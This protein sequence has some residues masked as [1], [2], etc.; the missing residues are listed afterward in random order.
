MLLFMLYS[1]IFK[2][3]VLIILSPMLA[4]LSEKTS[5]LLTGAVYPFSFKNF[6]QD[7]WR[8]IRIALRNTFIE[9]GWI[10]LFW[11]IG[12]VPIIGFISPVYLFFVS[13]YF[14]GF[15]MIDYN[16][17]RNR[18]SIRESIRFVRKN[19]GMAVANGMIFYLVFFFVPIIGFLVAPTYAI[20]AATLAVHETTNTRQ[21]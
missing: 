10:L 4:I 21:T 15:S 9:L 12:F 17:E 3:I 11:I 8:G 5:H 14:Y 7:V 13:C 20:I 19:R 18:L 16:N 2:Y 1:Y 6:M